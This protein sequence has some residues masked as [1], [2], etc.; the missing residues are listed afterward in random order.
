M[1]ITILCKVVDNFG[2]IGVVYRLAKQLKKIK[3]EN[4]INLVVDD[5]LSFQKICSSVQFEVPFQEVGSLNIYNWNASDFCHKAF[6]AD[7]GALMSVIL[8]CFQ[9]GRPDWMERILFEEK[10]QRTVQIIMLMLKLLLQKL[11]E[12][13]KL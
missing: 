12:K 4:Q 5:L 9:C 10:L 3:P 11:K 8:E 13:Q 6:S 2:D 7:D 1:Q